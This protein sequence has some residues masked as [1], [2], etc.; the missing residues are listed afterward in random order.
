MGFTEASMVAPPAVM[1]DAVRV[2]TV[3]PPGGA[4]GA[5][6]TPFKV[7]SVDAV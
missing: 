4:T 1:F 2:I 6:A 7:A 3:G 5:K